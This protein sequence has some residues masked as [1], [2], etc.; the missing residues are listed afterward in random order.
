MPDHGDRQRGIG[1]CT[2]RFYSLFSGWICS[3]TFRQLAALAKLKPTSSSSHFNFPK[4]HRNPSSVLLDKMEGSEGPIEISSSDSD[5]N[6]SSDDDEPQEVPPLPGHLNTSKRRLPS[7]AGTRG[8]GF[9]M[10]HPGPSSSRGTHSHVV[11]RV[12][13]ES[14]PSTSYSTG[15][16]SL[17]SRIGIGNGSS[18]QPRKND[19]N[20]HWNNFSHARDAEYEQYRSKRALPSSIQPSGTSTKQR[21]SWDNL[22]NSRGYFTKG[23]DGDSYMYD[24]NNPRILPHTLARGKPGSSGDYTTTGDPFQIM[25]GEES[26]LGDERLIYQAALQ[27]LGK[28]IS[29]IALILKQWP[30]QMK[31]K[32]EKRDNCF[33]E[34][35]NLDD[36]DDDTTGDKTEDQNAGKCK[37]AEVSNSEPELYNLDED[38][39]IGSGSVET[40]KKLENV[41]GLKSNPGSSSSRPKVHGKRPSAGTLIVCPATVLRQWARELSEKVARKANLSVL[42]YH[43]G[44]RTKDPLKLAKHDVVL[45]TYAI[46]SNEVPKQP[47]VDEDDAEQKP[48]E[49]YGLSSD[50]AVSK[51]R[52]HASTKKGKKGKKMDDSSLYSQAG[53]LARVNWFRVVLDEAQTIKN[54]RTQ[55]ARACCGLRAKRRW[56]LSGTPIQNSVDEMYS[57]FRFLR[58]HLYSSY[59]S[60]YGG[61]KNPISRDPNMGYKKLQ[62]VLRTL[63]LRR[64]KETLL[65]GEP[66]ICLPPKTI[67]MKTVNFTIEERSFYAQLEAESRSQ[68]KAYAAAGTVNQ[69]YANILLMILRL[70]QACDHPL[71]VKGFSSDT[72]RRTNLD[73]AR[74]LPRHLLTGLLNHLEAATAICLICSD[75]AEDAVVTIC[76]HVFCYQCVADYLTGGDTLCPARRCKEQL[77]DDA[78][79]SEATLKSCLNGDVDVNSSNDNGSSKGPSILSNE[80]S[81]SKIKAALEIL[82][83][84]YEINSKFIEPNGLGGTSAESSMSA[85]V[86]IEKMENSSSQGPIKTIV[87][88]QWT[89]MLDLFEYSLNLYCIPYRRLDG[90]MSLA[91]RDRAVREFNTIPEVTCMLMSLKAG[92]LGL[93][94]VAACHVI[95]LDLWWNP[96]TEDQAIDR[97]H[98]IGQTRPVT[99]SRITIK[100]TVEDRILALQEEKRKMVASAFGEDHV[101]GSEA[102]LTADDLRYLFLG[103]RGI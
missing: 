25:G 82:L 84:H 68:F 45:T 56:C 31:S 28:T 2:R 19:E 77:N 69:N 29:T 17:N 101:A 24:N 42:L 67:E 32:S 90:S 79:F 53:A 33:A 14:S 51:K 95:L 37:S 23:S 86:R 8:D 74:K 6:L 44:T 99:V 71:L 92:N 12:Q 64:T 52:K 36:D 85:H 50:F 63:L 4:E 34:A 26:V 62:A 61:I 16:K 65:D 100:D 54:H 55:T 102:R 7:W 43:G 89:R 22:G 66:I 70:R 41:D 83:A 38:D 91:A 40:V 80:Y 9:N 72:A 20:S 13:A 57:Y 30:A 87:F 5:F 58:H 94:M 46:V 39:D 35:L 18:F 88:S 3:L 59:K 49:R 1:E 81:S 103:S 97:A 48:G 11:H 76:G 78:L 98:R 27:G 75:P 73:N 10:Q 60:F 15:N 96:T 93:N 47:I 21:N